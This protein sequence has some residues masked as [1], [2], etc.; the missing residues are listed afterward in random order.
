MDLYTLL[1]Y[2]KTNVLCIRDIIINERNFKIWLEK[3]KN[4][5]TARTYT[6]R[7]MRIEAEM[8]VDL[9]KEYAQDGGRRFLNK[10]KYSREEQRQGK[11]PDCGLHFRENV[12]IYTG[13][14]S[15]RVSLKKY[16]EFKDKEDQLYG[17]ITVRFQEISAFLISI[18]DKNVDM[19]GV[20]KH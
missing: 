17:G 2:N 12:D 9:D 20:P 11:Q 18:V 5:H 15:L 6:A 10:L 19:C 3:Q 8:E 14:N 1:H 4:Y 7:C 16:F 13:L